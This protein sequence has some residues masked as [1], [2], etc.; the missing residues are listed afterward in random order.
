MH[1]LYARKTNLYIKFFFL[2]L[3]LLFNLTGKRFIISLMNIICEGTEP[4]PVSNEN[5]EEVKRS[6]IRERFYK[7]SS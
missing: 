4:F 6:F 5:N 2:H 3:F 7:S 1:R